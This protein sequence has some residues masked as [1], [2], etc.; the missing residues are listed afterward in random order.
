VKSLIAEIKSR[1]GNFVT[2]KKTWIAKQKTLAMELGDWD[3]SYNHLPRWLQA[4]QEWDN[5]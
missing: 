3:E 1:Y 4:V 5:F 2:Y